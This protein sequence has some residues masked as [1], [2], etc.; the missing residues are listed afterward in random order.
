MEIARYE[1]VLFRK[2]DS[3]QADYVGAIEPVGSIEQAARVAL[4]N[5]RFS[6]R[7]GSRCSLDLRV[8]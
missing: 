6:G 8:R 4:R 2:L 7:D 3:N 1:C 5:F